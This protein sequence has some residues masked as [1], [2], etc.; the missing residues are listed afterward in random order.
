MG[1]HRSMDYYVILQQTNS[2]YKVYLLGRQRKG[3][4]YHAR[5]VVSK[6]NPQLINHVIDLYRDVPIR[7]DWEQVKIDVMKRALIAKFSQHPTLMD[8]LLSTEQAIIAEQSHDGF[9]GIGLDGQGFNWLGRLLM[10]IRST[11]PHMK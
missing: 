3:K 8:V 5:L 11:E 10:E 9:W 6:A 4:G 7:S 2:P 1:V